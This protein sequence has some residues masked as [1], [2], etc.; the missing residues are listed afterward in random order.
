MTEPLVGGSAALVGGS[1]IDVRTGRVTP[2]AAIVI[3]GGK[4]IEV[5]TADAVRIPTGARRIDTRGSWLIPGLTDMHVHLRSPAML[6]I[7]LAYG[8][9]TVR[10]CGGG[11]TRARLLQR[12]LATGRRVGPRFYFV[13]PILD[14]IPPLWPDMTTLVET[15]LTAEAAVRFL[16]T[17]GVAAVKVYNSVPETS[18]ETIVRVAHELGL[19]VTGHVPRS[20]TMTRAIEIGMDGLEHIRITGREMLAADEAAQLDYLPVGRRETLLWGRYDLASPRFDALVA[21][22]ASARV[23]LDPTF[24]VDAAA[25]RDER[26]RSQA[27]AMVTLPPWVGA[28]IGQ[29]V[30]ARKAGDPQRVTDMPPELRDSARIGFSKRQRFIGMC[31]SAGVRLVTGTDHTGLG[32]DLPGRGVQRELAYLVECGLTPLAALRASTIVAAEALGRS[33]ELG[34]IERG[35][36]ADLLVL[37]ADPL[38]DV[39]N[40]GAIRIVVT[41]GRLMTPADLLAAPPEAPDGAYSA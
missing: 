21:R 3:D 37:N 32:D 16:A 11:L 38:T 15:P 10:E 23:F 2:N 41:A 26:E 13:G 40:V 5:G 12:D 1:L 25:L 31:A 17:Q 35:K 14:G 18:L 4:I 24:V 28:A 30:G 6:P 22:L 19:P 20:M 29:A 34:S 8:V 7:Y 33:D 36:A 39:R 27:E 9:T